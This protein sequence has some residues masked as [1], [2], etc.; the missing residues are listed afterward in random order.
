MRIYLC[1]TKHFVPY[2]QL[3]SS[4]DRSDSTAASSRDGIRKKKKQKKK[5]QTP[6]PKY[7]LV[8]F[9]AG[10]NVFDT[11]IVDP[12]SGCKIFLGSYDYATDAALAADLGIRHLRANNSIVN[13][14]SVDEYHAA[15]KE[16]EEAATVP[17]KCSFTV[18]EI[19]SKVQNALKSKKKKKSPAKKG[20]KSKPKSAA[21]QAAKTNP[22]CPHVDTIYDTLETKWGK[23][24]DKKT[25]REFMSDYQHFIQDTMRG[26]EAC[27][28][29]KRSGSSDGGD[30]PIAND[31]FSNDPNAARLPTV[32]TVQTAT[33][34][35]VARDNP[36]K[37]FNPES[38]SKKEA[39]T[40]RTLYRKLST[41]SASEKGESRKVTPKSFGSER[42]STSH[43][44]TM[45]VSFK[46]IPNLPFSD[47]TAASK[48]DNDYG[49][50]ADE[51]M[52]HAESQQTLPTRHVSKTHSESPTSQPTICLTDEQVE[53]LSLP[54]PRGCQVW[55]HLD[56]AGKSSTSFRQGSVYEIRMSVMS[57][58]KECQYYVKETF[59]NKTLTLTER[60]LCYAPASPI[61][62]KAPD[63]SGETKSGEIL[64]CR[65]LPNPAVNRTRE[66]KKSLDLALEAGKH[67]EIAPLLQQ[68]DEIE[69]SRKILAETK[70]GKSLTNT[71]KCSDAALAQKAKNIVQK[72][73][74]IAG[75]EKGGKDE[76]GLTFGGE[77]VFAYN[78]LVSDNEQNHFHIE[79]GVL[80]DR[81]QYRYVTEDTDG[82]DNESS[83]STIT[84]QPNG[85]Y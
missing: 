14:A 7:E 13:F 64:L 24:L 51:E 67:E 74:E 15:K 8:T 43:I 11:R 2:I 73:K 79:E 72:W 42:S 53:Q 77:N 80:P 27:D 26:L 57:D 48:P 30:A 70:V 60:E 9:N 76:E 58:S 47:P 41:G 68:L 34:E 4:L 49:D 36:R 83:N 59:S 39:P 17:G 31:P 10:N 65:A 20:S 5:K 81:V 18:A 85:G 78:V 40:F 38:P 29:I 84:T 28:S 46:S 6:A 61:Y 52:P 45:E 22:P 25:G 66:L 19:H 82:G 3:G 71:T 75:R 55:Y 1:S 50:K 56:S 69:I 21:D 33:E 35:D 63:G 37:S 23:H 44:P 16:E 32:R 54:F 12:A 62:L